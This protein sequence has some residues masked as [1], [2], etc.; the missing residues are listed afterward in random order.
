MK[1]NSAGNARSDHSN[2]FYNERKH[3]HILQVARA[4]KFQAQLPTQFWGECALT[5]VHVI[6]RLLSFVL[7]FKTSFEC[8][9]LKPPTYSHLRVFGCLAYATNVHVS[10]KFD[11]CAIAC[12]FIGYLVGQ[13]A[14]KLFNL[15]NKKIFTSRNVRFHENHFP[16]ASFE[17]VLPTSNLG[18][19]SRS[20]PAP[21]H[22]PTPSHVTNP[23]RLISPPT[24]DFAPSFSIAPN[25]D[26]LNSVAPISSPTISE[27]PS[28][29]DEQPTTNL[30]PTFLKTYTRRPKNA[31]S[32]LLE[33]LT[34]PSP[35]P[36]IETLLLT[37]SSLHS[38]S[39][40]LLSSSNPSD[41]SPAL[42]GPPQSTPTETLHRSSHFHNP[43]TKQ[44]DYV[45]SHITHTCS[46]QSLSLLPGPTKGTRYP[47]ANYVSY[48]C[49]KPAH[50]SSISQISQVT[51]PRNYSEVVVHPEW[52]E[53]M[54]FKLQALQA[55][56]TWTLTSLPT[57]KTLIGCRWVH[58]IEHRSDES[59]EIYK[60]RL[61]A[62]GFT[63]LEGV[64]YQDTFSPIAKII[65]VRCLLALATAR[66]WPLH[67]LDAN[68]V[69][70]H[71]DRHEEI[72]MSPSPGLRI[73]GEENLV[74]QLHKSLYGLKQ[75][76]RQWFSKFSKAIRFTGN[77]SMSISIIKKFLHSQFHLKDLGD[78]K[79]FLGIE[80]SSSKNGIFISQ[81][82]KWYDKSDLLKDPGHYRRFM[83]QP[84]KFHMEATLHVVHY[85]KNALG[86]GLFFSLNSDFRDLG[87]LHQELALLYCDNKAALHIVA[88][89]VFH[90][91]TGH[92]EMDCHYIQDK[93]QDGFVVIVFG[94]ICVF[95]TGLLG[96]FL[97]SFLTNVLKIHHSQKL[98][99][100]LTSS[101]GLIL[102]LCG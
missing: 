28:L 45:F 40:L 60:A 31:Y 16:Y 26:T 55:N 46:D 43:P 13:K 56:G 102:R 9:Y 93:I 80:V 63:Q 4:L 19:F 3:R 14:Y 48:H 41:P 74:C 12:I 98:V 7:F 101:E 84:C 78:L 59:I 25:S 96:S 70:L 95:G 58:K 72:Y 67:Q 20:I 32:S 1:N 82:L 53:A 30:T 37:T 49:Y 81:R 71:D 8:L 44:Q 92:I 15:S 36:S 38:S 75:A 65:T 66:R 52:Q 97:F 50:C 23:S 42:P 10:H 61:V 62:K 51:K 18:Y 91:R 33:I 83:H 34:P 39:S 64:D 22:D 88:N 57:G 68:S 90:E 99:F 11:Y 87:V 94:Y 76:S 6:N 29:H 86:Q 17:S 2:R 47:L 21:I 69:F 79:Y 73:Q 77:G 5:A 89:L 85:L 54:R 27:L 24:T 35:S 100:Q